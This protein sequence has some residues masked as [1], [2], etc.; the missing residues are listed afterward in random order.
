MPGAQVT[1]RHVN[2][3][4]LTSTETGANGAYSALFLVPGSYEVQV[5][6]QGFKAW[7]RGGLVLQVNDR[8]RIDA[9]LEIGA[10]EGA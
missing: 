6:L 10:L 5:E 3:N 7:R 9:A 4:T 1:I 8:L 2:R